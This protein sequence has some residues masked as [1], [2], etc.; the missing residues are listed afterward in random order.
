MTKTRNNKFN[1]KNK[2]VKSSGGT[3][4]SQKYSLASIDEGSE[5]GGFKHS[6]TIIGI[7]G[8]GSLLYYVYSKQNIYT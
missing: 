8:V 4:L 1:K 6:N 2:S 5:L 3:D 7:L